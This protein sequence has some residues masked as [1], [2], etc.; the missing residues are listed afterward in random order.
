MMN[1]TFEIDGVA[2]QVTYEDHRFHFDIAPARSAACLA[3][4][5]PFGACPDDGSE[6]IS[7]P[8]PLTKTRPIFECG[9]ARSKWVG[10]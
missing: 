4:Y 9:Y 5:D 7:A 6:R 3:C 2:Y 8:T 1:K 10:V